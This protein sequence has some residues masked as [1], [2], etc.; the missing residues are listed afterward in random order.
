VAEHDGAVYIDTADTDGTVIRIARGRW[1]VVTEAP[2]KFRRTRLT[3]EMDVPRPG[4][5]V[6]LLW[7]FVPIDAADRPVLLAWLLAALILPDAPHPILGLLAEQG[8]AKSSVT[9]CLVDLIDPSP[10]P[11][12]QAPRDADGWI[13]A[14]SASWVVALDN[15]SGQLPA[16]LSDSLCRAATGDGSVRR[17]LYTD[18]DVAVFAFR[19]CCIL[20]G[21]DLRF[22]A[23][24]LAER[25]ASM[26]LP[27]IDTTHRRTESELGAAWAE[28]APY[29]LGGLLD[30]AAQV[31]QTLPTLSVPDLPRMAD[32]ATV[33]AG[34]DMVLGT[35]GLDRYRSTA[36]KVAG[37]TLDHPFTAELVALNQRF[38]ERTSKEILAALRPATPDWKPPRDWPKNA[39]SATAQLTRDAPALRGQGWQ[40]D[41]DGGHSKDGTTRWTI[42]PP[43]TE[44]ELDP[45]SPPNPHAQ[46]KSHKSGGSEEI[47]SPATDP[48][49]PAGG[50]GGEQAGK[51]DSAN[52]PNK[53]PLSCEDGEA[54]QAGQKPATSLVFAPPQ[55]HC[56]NDLYA[57]E[58]ISRGQCER[59]H[60]ANKPTRSTTANTGGRHAG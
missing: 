47:E 11:L 37:D 21:I 6:S 19:R 46:I 25:L 45:P 4:G 3:G 55:C 32:F 26:Q 13:T 36:R 51:A 7:T 14:A 27:R 48:P 38:E 2:V 35:T 34:V 24:D 9:R 52:P 39:R 28:A 44:G 15:L 1:T 16:W 58:S 33:L 5:D 43:E 23:G 42:T 54:G 10:V 18:S 12:R 40:I 49:F 57:A 17:A 20:N 22:D 31:H 30:L 29:V 50:S 53:H 41:N 8:S 60:L 59:C 56:G